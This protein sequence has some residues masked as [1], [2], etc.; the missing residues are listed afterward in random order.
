MKRTAAAL[1]PTL[2]FI[3]F[4]SA[5]LLG[6]AKVLL[7][8]PGETKTAPDNLR[9]DERFFALGAPAAQKK[10][11]KK[12]SAYQ[13]ES[14]SAEGKT[15]VLFSSAQSRTLLGDRT[16][17]VRDPLSSEE[18]LYLIRDSIRLYE[19]YDRLIL[20]DAYETPVVPAE[21]RIAGASDH[22]VSCYHGDYTEFSYYNALSAYLNKLSDIRTVILYRIWLFDSGTRG[23]TLESKPQANGDAFSLGLYFSPPTE[24]TN[25][26]GMRFRSVFCLLLD[27]EKRTGRADYDEY[28]NELELRFYSLDSAPSGPLPQTP[29]LLFFDYSDLLLSLFSEDPASRS[30]RSD[31]AELDRLS[32]VSSEAAQL[33]AVITLDG[34]TVFPTEEL[35]REK[36]VFRW[37]AFSL[38]ASEVK[39]S[40]QKNGHG[41]RSTGYTFKGEE[42]KRLLASLGS[43]SAFASSYGTAGHYAGTSDPVYT[44]RIELDNGTVFSIPFQKDLRCFITSLPNPNGAPLSYVRAVPSAFWDT[45]EELFA[46]QKGWSYPLYPVALSA[47]EQR[48]LYEFY[49][50]SYLQKREDAA[51]A[52]TALFRAIRAAGLSYLSE[53]EKELAAIRR[54]PEY[55]ALSALLGDESGRYYTLSLLAEE[56]YVPAIT[57]SLKSIL[58]EQNDA[59]RAYADRR[60]GLAAVSTLSFLSEILSDPDRYLP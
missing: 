33:G 44:Y 21:K 1:L 59:L 58:A 43:P 31:K 25:S 17:G 15:L 39:I 53:E 2:V 23:G 34:K 4:F 40:L 27:N 5:L 48:I 20:T 10:M 52:C 54:L 13:Y 16:N 19:S 46:T 37:K 38:D 8:R 51:A 41:L 29:M 49:S 11:E 18:I 32:A 60:G 35:E 12:F 47:T 24:R 14:K 56:K 55:A 28:Y 3:L 9:I 30:Y 22:T 7:L 6:W 26:A 57:L 50:V 42:A 45:L 36:P